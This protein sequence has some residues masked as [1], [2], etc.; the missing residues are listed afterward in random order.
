VSPVR[1]E[2][3]FYIQ[4]DGILQSH[5][6]SVHYVTGKEMKSPNFM[7]G[8]PKGTEVGCS[9]PRQGKARVVSLWSKAP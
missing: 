4:E 7:K 5:V 6:I 1:Y 3:G 9:S 2:L 8:L